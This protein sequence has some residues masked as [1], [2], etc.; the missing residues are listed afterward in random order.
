MTR[1]PLLD[2]QRLFTGLWRKVGLDRICF[3]TFDAPMEDTALPYASGKVSIQGYSRFA[4]GQVNNLIIDVT[5][6]I[7]EGDPLRGKMEQYIHHMLKIGRSH[8][9]AGEFRAAPARID[10]D[11][12][13][14]FAGKGVEVYFRSFEMKLTEIING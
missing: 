12:I 11:E 8:T 14:R 2:A 5:I 4:L 7:P 9:G 10:K 6:R 3:I 13:N 1:T